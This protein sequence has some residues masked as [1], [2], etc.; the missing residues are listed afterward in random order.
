MQLNEL[1]KTTNFEGRQVMNIDKMI[2]WITM[3]Y[4]YIRKMLLF[5][6]FKLYCALCFIVV[7]TSRKGILSAP[8][9]TSV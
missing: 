1:I 8:S 6:L 2:V 3:C 7:R 9:L 4:T 5:A